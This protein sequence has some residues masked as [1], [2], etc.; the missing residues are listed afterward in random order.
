M[1]AKELAELSS[2]REKAPCT[3]CKENLNSTNRFSTVRAGGDAFSDSISV[4]AQK[5]RIERQHQEQLNALQQQLDTVTHRLQESSKKNKQQITEIES[6]TRDLNFYQKRCHEYQHEIQALQSV[7]EKHGRAESPQ[8]PSRTSQKTLR[9]LNDA[10]TDYER[11]IS[12]T[13]AEMEEYKL[14]IRVLEDALE[15]RANE[16][17]I[18]GHSDLLAKVA[19]LRGEVTALKNEL[20]QKDT[21]IEEAQQVT[22]S[23]SHDRDEL[24][25][26]VNAIQQR[27]AESQQDISRLA[28]GDIVATL[29][30]VEQE[31]DVLIEFIQA[32]MEKSTT[33][34][35]ELDATKNE[36]HHVTKEKEYF[37]KQYKIF[38]DQASKESQ[39]LRAVQNEL[40]S[41]NTKYDEVMRMKQIIENQRS[42]VQTLYDKKCLEADELC[43]MQLTLFSQV[44]SI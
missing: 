23:L 24:R 21:L 32:D 34:A 9:N 6:L 17:G 33:I 38:E 42:D 14:H 28:H 2:R 4:A 5:R 25:N 8:K 16:L 11:K 27:L 31:R 30:A 3:K 36:L 40:S 20:T 44:V 39:K 29:K 37:E 18:A 7:V 26:K 35:K 19:R 10:I 22:A 12:E 43:Q 41:L 1:Q 13:Q 15:F